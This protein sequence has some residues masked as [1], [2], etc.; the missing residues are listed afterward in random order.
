M[1]DN[2]NYVVIFDMDGVL[3]DSHRMIWDSVNSLLGE[4]G[5]HLSEADIQ[6]YLGVSLRDDLLAWNA[7]YGLCL[8]LD[9][10]RDKLWEKEVE[11]LQ[12]MRA[13]SKLLELLGDL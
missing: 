11:F 5:V 3:V 2:G 1:K 9:S 4:Q 13:D 6:Q 8:D 7:R 12:R 10:F